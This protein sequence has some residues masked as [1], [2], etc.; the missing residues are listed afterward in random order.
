EN[1]YHDSS[2]AEDTRRESRRAGKSGPGPSKSRSSKETSLGAKPTR[3]RKGKGKAKPADEVDPDDSNVDS[4][5]GDF[6]TGPIPRDIID[7]LNV[8]QENFERKVEELA[9]ECGKSAQT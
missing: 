8:A 4:D 9:S 1:G 7:R 3:K 2:E 5:D 6:K